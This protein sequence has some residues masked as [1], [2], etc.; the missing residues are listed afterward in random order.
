MDTNI[1]WWAYMHVNGQI[2]VK[3]YFGPGDLTEADESP[4]IERRTGPFDADNR[5]EAMTIAIRKL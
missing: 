3:R 2:Q 5:D 1:K 4:F